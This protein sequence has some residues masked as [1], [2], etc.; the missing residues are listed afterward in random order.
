MPA[1]RT[2]VTSISNPGR[3]I[4][5]SRTR[6]ATNNATKAEYLVKKHFR[7]NMKH[8]RSTKS[9]LCLAA[10]TLLS[11]CYAQTKDN[12]P[13]S[14]T[15][16]SPPIG[17]LSPDA[18]ITSTGMRP[19]RWPSFTQDWYLTS[20]FN[21]T[22]NSSTLAQTHEFQGY[23]S[24]PMN[25]NAR[26]CVIMFSGMNGT[27]NGENGCEGLISQ[28]CID[29]LAVNVTSRWEGNATT[30]DLLPIQNEGYEAACGNELKGGIGNCKSTS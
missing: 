27:T 18:P 2:Y 8:D 25:A 15:C 20:T 1:W 4:G 22:R 29:Y 6:H 19:F 23:I 21:D 17:L 7:S 10:A 11:T 13:L 12:S 9:A 14:S 5:I 30:C 16:P 28:R 3:Q 26:A 24:A